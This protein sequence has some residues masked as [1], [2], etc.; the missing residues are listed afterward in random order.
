MKCIEAKIVV[1]GAQGECVQAATC[2]RMLLFVVT[3]IHFRCAVASP[4]GLLLRIFNQ[5]DCESA[6]CSQGLTL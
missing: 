4:I 3:D 6:A 2:D 1:L 5:S